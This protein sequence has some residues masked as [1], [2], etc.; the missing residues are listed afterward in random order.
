[1]NMDFMA[2]LSNSFQE[3]GDIFSHSDM[4]GFPIDRQYT[5]TRFP[6]TSNS[7]RRDISN[8]GIWTLSSAKLGF[9]IQQLREDSLS[10]Y[11][12]SDGSQP[13]TVTV[14]FPRK[15]YVSEFCIYLDFKSDESYTPS[16]MSILIGNAM[17][18]MREVQNVELEE[19]TGWYNFALGKLINGAYNPI[20]THYVQ[21]VILQNQHNGRDTHIR[22]MKI[23]GLR[24]EPVIAFPVFIENSYSKY[25]M[26][27]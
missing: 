23:L 27:R 2:S 1:M 24:E 4:E 5:K 8:M 15:V 17:T 20:K 18:D 25:T 9:G 11:W 14:Y 3:L 12:Q 19:P 7:Q 13:H 6:L 10:A 22:N 21:L 26:M 16:K